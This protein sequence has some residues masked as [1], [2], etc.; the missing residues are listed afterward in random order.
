MRLGFA[1]MLSCLTLGACSLGSPSTEPEPEPK[2]AETSASAPT[3]TASP[4][5]DSAVPWADAEEARERAVSYQGRKCFG[6]RPTLVG[7]PGDDRIR[8]TSGNDVI[9]TL[10]GDDLIVGPKGAEWMESYCT[11]TGADQVFYYQ[12]KYT[13]KYFGSI[14]FN[15][16]LGPGDDRVRVLGR[17]SQF[18][19]VFA[20][21]GN[22][23]IILGPESS[24]QVHP[25]PGDD[26][27]RRPA[28]SGSRRTPC[29]DLGRAR[30]PVRIDLA[31]GRATGQGHDR[32]SP[33][34]RCAVGG[35]FDDV[36]IGTASND[37]LEPG[38]GADLV[39]AGAG[40]DDVLSGWVWF[41]PVRGEGG[42]RIYLGPG[43]DSGDGGPGADRLY[44]GLGSDSLAGAPGSD[45]LDG[46]PGDDSLHAGSGCISTEEGEPPPFLAEA[47]W[48]AAP[49][50]VFG[51]S[52]N[53]LLSG[54]RGNDR[55]DG[56]PGFDS[57][58]G[59]YHDGRIDWI[60]SVE[61]PV[62]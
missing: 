56:G 22:D 31:R 23:T 52:G 40:D 7:T 47:C 10:G 9:V 60:T 19:Q 11:G 62:D 50:E 34:I 57:G 44:G 27:I 28:S 46:G 33:N 6:D 13:T 39:R 51:R 32:F 4:A 53:D 29:I 1:A 55:L 54:D 14:D 41:W 35:R 5:P 36:L 26:L 20:G 15:I 21:P 61:R 12:G 45:Y 48:D 43:D 8:A 58:S 18:N 16:G 42:D 38:Y 37:E 30:S 17:S 3:A 49:N 24:A 59:G 25:G 2:E